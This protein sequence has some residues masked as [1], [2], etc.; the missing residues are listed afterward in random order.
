MFRDAMTALRVGASRRTS[1]VGHFRISKDVYN[2]LE[3]EARKSGVSL[4]TVVNQVLTL[5]SHDDVIW[6]EIGNVRLSKIAFRAFLSRIP[7]DELAELGSL[8]AKDTPSAMMLARTGAVNLD[9]ILDYL[10]FRSRSGWFSFHESKNNG[11]EVLSFVH[12]FGPR[13]SVLL[14]S[15]FT[16]LFGLVGIHPKVTT[17]NSSVMV[18]Y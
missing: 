3:D 7:D 1:V 17:T 13:D 12:E 2:S 4:N 15:Y 11:K 6:Q 10:H 18:E 16:S 9:A 8:L 14:S 5:H